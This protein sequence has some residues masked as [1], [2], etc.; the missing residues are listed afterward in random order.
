M[1]SLSTAKEELVANIR[2]QLYGFLYAFIAAHA[3]YLCAFL[4]LGV[5]EMAF[6]NIFSVALFTGLVVLLRRGLVSKI[7][8]IEHVMTLEFCIHQ[9]LAVYFTGMDLGFQFIL[10]SL[11]VPFLNYAYYEMYTV[12]AR[13]R[14][15]AGVFLYLML[16]VLL[17]LN[18]I[19][20]KYSF[21]G[22]PHLMMT[23]LNVIM[24]FLMINHHV[25][26]GF[27]QIRRNIEFFHKEELE[28]S[29][30]TVDMQHK[31]INNIASIIED[32]DTSTGLHTVRTSALVEKICH[33]LARNQRYASVLSLARIAQ[34]T[35]CAALHDIGK[36]KISDNIL[37][38]PGKLTPEEF[39]IMKKHTL[40]GGEIIRRVFHDIEDYEYEQ[41]A[42]EIAV[43][44]HERWDG[45]GYP[46]SLS[47][48]SIPLV[49]RIMAVADVYDAQ[50]SKRIYKE[51]VDAKQAVQY[52][53][54]SSGTQFDPNVVEAFLCIVDVND[55]A[56]ESPER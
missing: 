17:H 49:A 5:M 7:S 26:H 41:T 39:E 30:K 10:L 34:I 24:V 32:R 48:E 14:A 3:F 16:D 9:C 45:T 56:T 31:L 19:V 4:Y 15:I 25:I 55:R 2:K 52:I 29:L 50:I 23:S 11:S 35:E 46:D 27:S 8:V 33:E 53:K 21:E 36:I 44:H 18:I 1:K 22:A 20:P 12:H 6:Y 54:E 43:Y 51:G 47:G 38:K 28:L 40:Y 13:I 37:N 42:Y